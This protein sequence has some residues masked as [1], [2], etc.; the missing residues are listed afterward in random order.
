[1]LLTTLVCVERDAQMSPPLARVSLT[2]SQARS[3]IPK[4]HEA[5]RKA[6]LLDEGWGWRQADHHGFE[7]NTQCS[8]QV[9]DRGR[10]PLGDVTF[11]RDS[12]RP[13]GRSV[14]SSPRPSRVVCYSNKEALATTAPTAHN[15]AL[16]V[17]RLALRESP[18]TSS[19]C[20]SKVV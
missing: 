18:K 20:L 11:A 12:G 16:I 1:M 3:P 8:H 7:R 10:M 9:G 5:P 13:C 6:D 2:T 14:Q 19:K 17:L 4:H 15:K